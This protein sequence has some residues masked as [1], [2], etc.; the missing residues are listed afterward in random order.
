MALVLVQYQIIKIIKGKHR[1]GKNLKQKC[2]PW[3][4]S[5]EV[6]KYGNKYNTKV[7]WSKL[8]FRSPNQSQ[9]SKVPESLFKMGLKSSIFLNWQDQQI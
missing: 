9:G 5:L 8:L 6:K 7:K 1:Q 4:K 2:A 3:A